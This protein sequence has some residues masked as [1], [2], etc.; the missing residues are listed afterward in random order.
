MPIYTRAHGQEQPYWP[1]GPFKIRLPLV[2]YRLELPEFIQGMVMFVVG[3]GLIPLLQQT[4][5]MSFEV[6]LAFVITFKVFMLAGIALGVPMFPGFIT[7]GIPIVLIYLSD[8]EPG[9]EAVQAVFALQLLVF[10][11]MTVLGV[12]RLGGKLVTNLPKFIK[13]GILIG[14]G[15]AALL[16]EIS[17]GESV[18]ETPVSIV[19]GALL[20]FIF[21]FSLSFRRLAEKNKLARLIS[22]YGRIPPMLIAI[23]I[24]WAVAEYPRPD[25]E[26]CIAKPD[27]V[28]MF[29]YTPFAVGLLP[30]EVFLLAIP[31]AIIA[32]VIAFGNMVVGNEL[33]TNADK[34]R[35]DEKIDTSITR[36]HLVTGVR[37]LAVALLAP[38]RRWPDRSGPP[39]TPP[40]WNAISRAAKPWTPSMAASAP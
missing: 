10:A 1:L 34:V 15:I 37:N 32:Y 40:C 30:A 16:G 29:S 38:P 19:V 35:Q 17:E 36:L 20:S 25:V 21:L 11:L 9:P 26:C 6:A 24:G 22:S 23:A 8:C 3:L 27:F 28:G 5:G 18:V 2:H 4:M 39:D 7:A 13:A 31:T 12:T 33:T 14:A